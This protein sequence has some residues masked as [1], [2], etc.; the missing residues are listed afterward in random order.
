MLV[1][2]KLEPEIS[3][4]IGRIIEIGDGLRSFQPLPV[5]IQFANDVVIAALLPVFWA[6]RA[7]GGAVL[8]RRGKNATH[9]F[10]FIAVIAVGV[11]LD[12][13]GGAYKHGKR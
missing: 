7:T 13:L 3:Q 2:I 12:V 6:G 9:L 8:I 4:F 11:V 5:L 1:L 10:E